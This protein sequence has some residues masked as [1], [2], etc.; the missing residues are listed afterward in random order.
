MP[1]YSQGKIYRLTCANLDLVYYG[2]T[3]Q[4]LKERLKGHRVKYNAFKSG[5][6]RHIYSSFKLF[7][8]GDVEIELVIDCSCQ[9]KRELEEVEQT[10][11][12]NDECVNDRRSF[13]TKENNR[14][15]QLNYMKN[16]SLTEEQLYNKRQYNKEYMRQLRLKQK[17]KIN[18]I[19]Y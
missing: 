17:T 4:T 18:N 11:I 5:K 16:Y 10:F 13:M 14:E 1:D 8:V 19:M 3:V 2:S 9:S 15:N 6:L 12:D 7:E